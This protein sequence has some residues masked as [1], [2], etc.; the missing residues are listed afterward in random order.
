MCTPDYNVAF[1]VTRG[2]TIVVQIAEMFEM[3]RRNLSNAR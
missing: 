1:V 2:R 3:T